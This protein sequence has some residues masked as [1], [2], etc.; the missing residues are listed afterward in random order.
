MQHPILKALSQVIFQAVVDLSAVTLGRAGQPV[1]VEGALD[2]WLNINGPGD[3]NIVHSHPNAT[4]SGVYY[5]DVGSQDDRR[6]HSG[7]IEFTDP[8]GTVDHLE[9]PVVAHGGNRR[10]KPADAM[11]ILFPGYLTHFVH[12][13]TGVGERITLAFNVQIR[14]VK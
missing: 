9:A 10:I 1:S 12:P 2:G 4:W 6:P 7:D 5:I 14:S 8:R 13:Y 3:Y 11:M